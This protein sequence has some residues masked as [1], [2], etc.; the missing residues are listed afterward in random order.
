[1]GGHFTLSPANNPLPESQPVAEDSSFI[2]RVHAVDNQAAVWRAGEAFIKAHHMDY[3]DMTREHVTL[4]FLKDRQPQ[5]FDFSNVLHH[6]ETDSRYFL[7]V[8][9]VPGQLLDEAWPTL[10]ETLRQHYIS[11]VADI[12]DRLA[13]WKGHTISGVDGPQLLERYLVKVN[14]KMPDA[15]SPQQL[16]GNCTEMCMDASTA[17][18]S[19]APA[20]SKTNPLPRR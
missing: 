8:S 17:D 1:M 4:Q 3:P 19:R 5:G 11:K 12:C 13:A 14:G 15:L 2:S 20:L 6:F 10:D 16:L 7:I 9:R 18:C